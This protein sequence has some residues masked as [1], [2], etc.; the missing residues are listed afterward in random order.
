MWFDSTHTREMKM[1]L[2]DKIIKRLNN[3]TIN[4]YDSVSMAMV[5][6]VLAE[7]LGDV[8]APRSC[9]TCDNIWACSHIGNAMYQ[10]G[11]GCPGWKL[12]KQKES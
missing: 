2:K 1:K 9:G 7:E 8:D 5:E 11:G 12:K 6:K 10:Y 3:H 4:G